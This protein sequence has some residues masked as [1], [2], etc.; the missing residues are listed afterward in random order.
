MVLPIMLC[1]LIGSVVFIF[2]CGAIT[3]TTPLPVTITTP[4]AIVEQT[5]VDVGEEY[6]NMQHDTI[7]NNLREGVVERSI[8]ILRHNGVSEKEIKKK[9]MESFSL[10]EETLDR[11]LSN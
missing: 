2:T 8:E 3:S 10:D 9:M 6:N 5:A 4:P 11:L 1:S 7:K